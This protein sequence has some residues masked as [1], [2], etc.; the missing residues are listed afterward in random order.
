MEGSRFH[1]FLHPCDLPGN[2]FRPK[3]LEADSESTEHGP[4]ERRG[5]RQ[6]LLYP[7]PARGAVVLQCYNLEEDSISQVR[8]LDALGRVVLSIGMRGSSIAVDV[9]SLNG[10][11]I[12]VLESEGERFVERLIIE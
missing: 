12:V 2:S 10:L 8:F 1:A 6:L 7:N 11:F 9:S 5:V 3:S 4:T